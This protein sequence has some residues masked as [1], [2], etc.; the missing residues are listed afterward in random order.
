MTPQVSAMHRCPYEFDP[1]PGIEDLQA[2]GRHAEHLGY[3]M[4]RSTAEYTLKDVQERLR[5]IGP[6]A[7]L[8]IIKVT[9][10]ISP[11]APLPTVEAFLSQRLAA[12]KPQSELAITDPFMFTSSR[13]DDASTYAK[14][15]ARLVT[16]L[17]STGPELT[18]VVNRGA[19]HDNVMEAVK[20]ELAVVLP[21]QQIQV[22]YSDAFHDRFW[23]ADRMRGV[24]VGASLNK[25]GSKI[26]LVDELSKDDVA[27][28]TNELA[29][30]RALHE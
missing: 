7:F 11:R 17:L 10:D 9:E 27:A 29:K 25:I 2:I 3:T 15:V 14:S 1:E 8:S 4:L 13:K 24:I 20:D 6:S 30:I 26:F 5:A 22:T 12:L 28:I 18:F 19:S 21:S 16:P 23:I